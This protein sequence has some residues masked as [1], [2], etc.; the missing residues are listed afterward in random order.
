[1]ADP[2]FFRRAGPFKLGELAALAGA[3]LSQGADPERLITDIAPLDEA[4]AEQVSFLDN[5]RYLPKLGR[6]QAGA[7][8]IDPAY[9]ERAPAGMDLLLT[10]NPYRG[11]ALVAQ[12]FYPV[13]PVEPG[14]HPTAVVHPTARVDSE[15]EVGAYAVIEAAAEVGAGCRIGPHSVVGQGVRVGAGTRIAAHVT[16]EYCLIGRDCQIHAGARIGARGFGFTLDPEGF[17]DV[18]QV[19]RVI[20]GDGVEIGA[21][22]TIDRG[23]APDTLVGDGTRIDNLVQLGHNVKVGRNCI[24]IAQSGVAGSTQLMDYVT[25][26]AQAGISGHL[27]LNKGAKVAAK[28]GV[29]RDIKAGETVGG[30]P[31]FPIRDFLRLVVTWQRQLQDKS[32]RDE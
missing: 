7:C 27:T 17:L 20:V 16:L 8:L 2:R 24:L 13:P 5:K 3:T 9:A 4:G 6:S 28:S 25:V 29:M 1:M 18:P 11:Y 21:N 10:G 23:A 22:T 19:G 30:F 32:D 14:I 31:A 12:R 26:A 15:A